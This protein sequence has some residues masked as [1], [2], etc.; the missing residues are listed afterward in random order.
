MTKRNNPSSRNFRFVL[1][2]EDLTHCAALESF[3]KFGSYV[4]ILHDK[5]TE[6]DGSLKK[7]HWHVVLMLD[8]HRCIEQLCADLGIASN[9]C[10]VINGSRVNSLRYLIHLDDPEKYQYTKNDVLGDPVGLERFEQ[11][12]QSIDKLS[13]AECAAILIQFIESKKG[14]CDLSELAHFALEN[15]CFPHLR[16]GFNLYR[17]IIKEHDYREIKRNLL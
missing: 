6:L 1:Y 5:C 17:S 10:Q 2:P 13:E 11:A 16:R 12:T 8:S 7:P 9:Y 15:G 4:Y 14:Y 3:E